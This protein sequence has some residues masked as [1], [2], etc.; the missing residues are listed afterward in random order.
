MVDHL[1]E[2]IYVLS[3]AM[4]IGT[5]ITLVPTPNIYEL[6]CGSQLQR[7]QRGKDCFFVMKT[8]DHEIIYIPGEHKYITIKFLSTMKL[9]RMMAVVALAEALPENLNADV[10]SRKGYL[11]VRDQAQARTHDEVRFSSFIGTR[12]SIRVCTYFD[13]TGAIFLCLV[14]LSWFFSPASWTV[15]TSENIWILLDEVF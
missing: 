4:S 14:P 11:G 5:T 13:R 1:A 3:T 15:I 7:L 10:G 9:L 12:N 2:A 6:S 8:R